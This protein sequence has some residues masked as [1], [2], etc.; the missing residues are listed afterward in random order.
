MEDDLESQY[1]MLQVRGKYKIFLEY[2]ITINFLSLIA[3]NIIYNHLFANYLGSFFEL[4]SNNVNNFL[5]INLDGLLISGLIK[6][7][8]ARKKN[9]QKKARLVA[10]AE[11]KAAIVVKKAVVA[12]IRKVQAGAKKMEVKMQKA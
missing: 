8:I 2:K 10:V 7:I 6:S 5:V 11:K 3:L 1:L 9:A 4:L 12:K